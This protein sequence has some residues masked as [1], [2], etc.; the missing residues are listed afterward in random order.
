MILS[1]DKL[2]PQEQ[3]SNGLSS[4][5]LGNCTNVLKEYYRIKKKENLVV[6][7]VE[8]KNFESQYDNND[9]NSIYVGKDVRLE[10]YDYSGRKLNLSIC[11]EYIK[12]MKYI[13]DVD[14]IRINEAKMFSAQDIDIFNAQDDFFNDI[15]HP[16]DNP[17]R[18][19][20]TIN[21][22][23]NDI[24]Q[25]V[26]FC[27]DGC[28]FNGID[29]N[30][31]IAN[32]LCKPSYLQEETINLKAIKSNKE[33]V[34]FKS[35]T[36]VFMENLLNCNIK[37]IKC[38]KLFL[39]E[40]I[41]IHNIGFYCMSTMIILQ[42]IFFVIYLIKRLKPLKHFLMKFKIN[43]KK[44]NNKLNKIKR[45]NKN[46]SNKN[47]KKRLNNKDYLIN[48]NTK[49][50][51]KNNKRKIYDSLNKKIKNES[52]KNLL[53]SS[54]HKK[55]K[56]T[57]IISNNYIQTI[58]I[59]N[60]IKSKNN[61]NFHIKLLNLDV[62]EFDYE[63]AII[64]DKRSYIKIYWGFFQ[65]SHII[66][67]TIFKNNKFELFVI[68]LSFLVFNFQISFF[69][70]AFFY[71]DEYISD[72]YHNNGVLDFISGLPKSIYSFVATLLITNI[73]KNLSS[74]KNEL[75]KIIRQ[76]I[77]YPNFTN[78]INIKLA[79]LGKKLIIYFI[80]VFLFESFF[81]YYVTLFCSIYKYSQ[82]YW[83]IGCLESFAIDLLSAM[84]ICLFLAIFRYISIKR[85]IKCLYILSNI[86]NALL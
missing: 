21:D 22:R 66:L 35:L 83:L 51:I 76:N 15:C 75:M 71:S 31:I 4:F 43:D 23:R 7:L 40:N 85:H 3:I 25:N 47:Q 53:N 52:M 26:T 55:A 57:I 10:I 36:N 19:D 59:N 64:Y 42:I 34:N 28:K 17:N 69:L 20:I 78:I 46:K 41:F 50:N 65:E 54:K 9:V 13:G 12:I 2:E 32:C 24:Y 81:F 80:L 33:K 79:K 1:T 62:Q 58:N 11:T 56:K 38:Y 29:Y 27:Q 84:V 14:K 67:D 74:S 44:N 77:K 63:E 6:V 8:L 39:N 45:H 5:D 72:A 82:K 49:K 68:K 70:N 30:L 60:P 37:V 86:I 61:K 16:Y 48:Q 18:K 73:L